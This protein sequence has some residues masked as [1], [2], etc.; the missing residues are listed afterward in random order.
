[1]NWHRRVT[2]APKLI[3]APVIIT[4]IM[5]CTIY[6]A[7]T[8]TEEAPRSHLI[9]VMLWNTNCKLDELFWDSGA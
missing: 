4:S 6:S 8:K 2:V 9:T 3:Y 7:I 1:M 5:R